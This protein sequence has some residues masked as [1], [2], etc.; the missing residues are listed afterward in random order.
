MWYASICE[1]KDS[2]DKSFYGTTPY[3]ACNG[4]LMNE[5]CFQIPVANILGPGITSCSYFMQT[6]IYAEATM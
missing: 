2:L 5:T 6:A 3:C 1:S 4:F